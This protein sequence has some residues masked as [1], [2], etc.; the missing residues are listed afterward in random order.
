MHPDDSMRA[1]FDK[2]YAYYNYLKQQITQKT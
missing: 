1:G 2:A